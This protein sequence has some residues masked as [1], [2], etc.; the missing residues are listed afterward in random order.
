[1]SLHGVLE[2]RVPA[3]W[4]Q[5]LKKLVSCVELAQVNGLF[6]ISNRLR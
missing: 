1:L 4:T 5:V 3:S 2:Q 6:R